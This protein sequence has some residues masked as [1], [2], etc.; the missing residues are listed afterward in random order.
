[1]DELKRDVRRSLTQEKLLNK[2][3][4]SRITVTDSDVRNYYDA[5]KLNS[6]LPRADL[7]TSRR[8]WSRTRETLNRAI[9]RNN[10]ATSDEDARKKIQVIKNRIDFR[11]RL[12]RAGSELL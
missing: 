2:E 12:R 6:N 1:M 11:G 10:K 5:H 4:N 8:L 7:I 9:C 3:I